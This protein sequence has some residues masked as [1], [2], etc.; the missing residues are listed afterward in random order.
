MKTSVLLV[1]VYIITVNAFSQ[2][3][4]IDD[5]YIDFA[6]PDNAATTMLGIAPNKVSRPGNVKDIGI[7]L[8]NT[9]SE[10]G[11]LSQG[12]SLEWSP[13]MTFNKNLK[14]YKE[15]YIFNRMQFSIATAK[16][17][18]GNGIDLAVGY[19]VTIIDDA[20]PYKD[21]VLINDIQTLM[22]FESGIEIIKGDFQFEFKNYCIDVLK[23]EGLY[24]LLINSVFNFNIYKKENVPTE[25]IFLQQVKNKALERNPKYS[26]DVLNTIT[27][28]ARK[29][30]VSLYDV[31]SNKGYERIDKL[32]G[33]RKVEYLK[34]K[35]NAKSLQFS[36]GLISSSDSS[37]IKTL[38][39]KKW[40]SFLGYA[41]DIS[42]WGQ[43][44]FQAEYIT[45]WNDNDDFKN[46]ASLGWRFI[47]GSGTFRGS[48]EGLFT[49]AEKKGVNIN[50]NIRTTAGI[51][52][53]MTDGLWL[54][55]AF[56]LDTPV[57]E[58]KS[59]TLLSLVN[60]KYTFAKK[61]RYDINQ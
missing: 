38:K 22:L 20:D 31:L 53:R 46:K 7:Q 8:L 12:L 4:N 3:N 1:F 10:S 52:F 50:R 33:D 58:F 18:Q 27:H 39:L 5:Y 44:L 16:Q 36:T 55:A 2:S 11:N 45:S 9:I 30:L 61:R 37:T 29:F 43:A 32:I 15:H 54:E 34:K 6:I 19:K 17:N 41:Q 47:G 35:W 28:Y 60:L 57:S 49:Y 25:G 24:D 48:F 40:S 23:D 13:L 26:E 51:E 56:G 21:D 14:T 42:N 59:S